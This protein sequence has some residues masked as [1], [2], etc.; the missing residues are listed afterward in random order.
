MQGVRGVQSALRQR[1]ADATHARDVGLG[2]QEAEVL[3]RKADKERALRECF[4]RDKATG[5]VGGDATR[6]LMLNDVSA[7]VEAYQK[8]GSKDAAARACALVAAWQ[9]TGRS[10]TV[11]ASCA[12]NLSLLDTRDAAVRG[13]R[14]AGK[15]ERVPA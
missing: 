1:L 12:F 13:G 4:E 10:G 11:S 14:R 3:R 8:C 5:D 2:E 6:P 7:L 15:N 9:S